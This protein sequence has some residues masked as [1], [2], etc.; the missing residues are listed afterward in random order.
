MEA[1]L[2]LL[3]LLLA[4]PQMELRYPRKRNGIET[5]IALDISNSMLCE[6]VVPSRLD[7]SKLLVEN[8]VDHFTNDK[9]GIDSFCG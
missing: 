4:R 7:K 2:A 9:I 6:D 3:I 8:L 5:I 1:A